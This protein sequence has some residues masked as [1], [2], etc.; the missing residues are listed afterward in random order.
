MN[1]I[2]FSRRSRI[3]SFIYHPG[4]ERERAREREGGREG[5][6]DRKSAHGRSTFFTVLGSNRYN[7]VVIHI[8]H[9]FRLQLSGV[10]QATRMTGI[11][12]PYFLAC[13]K[14]MVPLVLIAAYSLDRSAA[15]ESEPS[16][17][18]QKKEDSSPPPLYLS[19][20]LS[21][22]PLSPLILFLSQLK[23]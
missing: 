18:I 17:R 5:G 3:L 12:K 19:I 8:L 14:T 10:N 2:I 15:L 7:T 13:L 20:S 9:T 16:L 21:F 1:L 4:R 23:V 22:L 11:Q 6:G